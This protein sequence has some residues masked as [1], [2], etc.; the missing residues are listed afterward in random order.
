[1]KKFKLYHVLLFS[2]VIQGCQTVKQA[3]IADLNHKIAL[4]NTI[5]NAEIDSKVTESS[6]LAE[7]KRKERAADALHEKEIALKEAELE[8]KIQQMKLETMKNYQKPIK[9]LSK[10]K[11]LF[12]LTPEGDKF[13]SVEADIS[14]SMINNGYIKNVF[15]G[16][17]PE[18]SISL[19]IVYDIS[20]SLKDEFNDFYVF[21]STAQIQLFVQGKNANFMYA[22]DDFN[23]TGERSMNSSE[24][25]SNSV[26]KISDIIS[27]W[28]SE[29]A[30]ELYEEYL[31][32]LRMDQISSE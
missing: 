10:N 26:D 8:L 19:D 29:K 27:N 7:A 31:S 14:K 30:D 23:A 24:A 18:G 15:D 32:K 25:R 6:I 21:T 2:I 13:S 5:K 17:I 11:F 20:T 3:E 9:V 28:V 22:I 12:K 4:S 1:M 16:N